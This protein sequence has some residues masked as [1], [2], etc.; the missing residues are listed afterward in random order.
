[1][2][3][4]EIKIPADISGFS[5]R[6]INTIMN[7]VIKIKEKNIVEI[8]DMYLIVSVFSGVNYDEILSADIRDI[9]NVY[10]G[11]IKVFESYSKKRPPKTITVHGKKY[12]RLLIE[13][14]RTSGGWYVDMRVMSKEFQTKPELMASL[15]YIEE[16][17]SYAEK[18]KDGHVLNPSRERAQIFADHFPADVYLDLTAFFLDRYEY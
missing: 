9:K 1:M 2:R 12:R 7:V 17:M 13:E 11:C 4:K 18:D 8:E 16:G 10:E 5:I 14:G 6:E 15:S 3:I